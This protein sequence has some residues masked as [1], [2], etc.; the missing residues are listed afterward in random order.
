MCLSCLFQVS[1]RSLAHLSHRDALRI[2]A[3]SQH[4]ITMQIKG[5]RSSDVD[6]A[7]WEPLPLNLQHLNLPL[8]MLGAG[9]NAT[10]PSYPD[11]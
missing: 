10:S 5:Q 6:R 7:S 11:R 9:L 8:P 4:P 1:G 3:A 2:L